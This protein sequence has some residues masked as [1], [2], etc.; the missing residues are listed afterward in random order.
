M[1]TKGHR[2]F[3]ITSKWQIEIFER[4]SSLIVLAHSSQKYCRIVFF[5]TVY[6]FAG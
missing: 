3:K 4:K 1:A 2:V 6:C 5:K